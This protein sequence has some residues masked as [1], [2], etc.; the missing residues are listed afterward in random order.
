MTTRVICM[1]NFCRYDLGYDAKR[2]KEACEK[3]QQVNNISFNISE[4]QSFASCW[5]LYMDQIS[6]NISHIIWIGNY[7][8]LNFIDHFTTRWVKTVPLPDQTTQS[9]ARTLFDCLYSVFGLPLV[10]R[11]GHNS[12]FESVMFWELCSLLGVKNIILHLTSPLQMEYL[13]VSR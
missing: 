10:I 1:L 4:V 8:I 2:F 5:C 7:I 11:S 6:V 3:C 12:M 13:C 9:C